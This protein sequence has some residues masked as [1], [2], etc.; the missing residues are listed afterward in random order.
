MGKALQLH[1]I[2]DA[3]AHYRRSAAVVFAGPDL[4]AALAAVNERIDVVERDWLALGREPNIVVNYNPREIALVTALHALDVMAAQ[5]DGIPPPPDPVAVHKARLAR[6]K[7]R[8][9]E[10]AVA[11]RAALRSQDNAYDYLPNSP[12]DAEAVAAIAREEFRQFQLAERRKRAK[13]A[14]DGKPKPAAPP[15]ADPNQLSLF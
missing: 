2:R 15:P 9:R 11:E 14:R 4:T 13:A 5:A 1:F 12:I 10:R 6:E 7:E 8:R 3:I